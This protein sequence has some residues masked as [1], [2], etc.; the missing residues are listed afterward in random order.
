MHVVPPDSGIFDDSSGL[1][2]A[3][4][5][6][7]VGIK[8]YQGEREMAA[9]NKLLGQF[10]L[11]GIPPA[12]R[13]IP[14]IEVTFDVDAN[15]IMNISAVDKS[16]GK[17]QQITIQSSGG[18]SESQINQM[19]EDAERYKAEDEKHKENVAAR[20][21]AESLLYNVE[22]QIV[23]LKVRVSGGCCREGI[24]TERETC[25]CCPAVA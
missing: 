6:S 22:K 20:N 17:R 3:F 5:F 12:P 15:G 16:T 4:V 1:S 14:Q 18:L 10:D 11:V 25:C 24:E 7:Q 23:D 8:V 19:V 21:E 2:I 9:A 13:G